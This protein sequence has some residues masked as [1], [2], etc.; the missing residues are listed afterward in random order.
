MKIITALLAVTV[1]GGIAGSASPAFAQQASYRQS[2]TNIDAGAET[3][4]ATCRSGDGRPVR[5]ALAGYSRCVGDIGNNNGILQCSTP[6]GQLRGRVIAES[7]P[8][9]PP[10]G[11]SP[12]YGGAPPYGAP[13]YG[14]PPSYGAPPPPPQGD[15]AERCRNWR[16]EAA[17]LRRRLDR[18][19]DPYKRHRLEER[20]HDV[21][22][23]LDRCRR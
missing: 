15:W 11:G 22:A 21:R 10:Y 14:G 18:E 9:R 2:C 1:L 8:Q 23:R 19:Y 20:L 7:G 6:G 17:H 13:P 3:L 4:V 16:D 5:S 12:S